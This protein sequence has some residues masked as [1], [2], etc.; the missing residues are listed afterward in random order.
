M[1]FFLWEVASNLTGGYL[2]PES[3]QSAT[4]VVST[5]ISKDM[6]EYAKKKIINRKP[7]QVVEVQSDK[8]KKEISFTADTMNFY[9]GTKDI[10]PKPKT[11]QSESRKRI[12]RKRHR[13]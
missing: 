6:Y 3:I 2:T 4:F 13:K 11:R 8:G 10:M 9:V 1:P 5:L 7:K 12:Q